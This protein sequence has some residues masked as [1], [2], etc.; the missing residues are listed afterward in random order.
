MND[1][2]KQIIPYT[3]LAACLL[4]ACQTD[5]YEPMAGTSGESGTLSLTVSANDFAVT[6]GAS[7]RAADNGKTTTFE[8]GDR[9]GL[10]VLD[11]ADGI[12]ADNLPYKFDGSNWNFD[13]NNGE[14]KQPAFYDPSMNTYIVY[15]PYNAAANQTA[16]VDALKALG[17][18]AH[19]ADQSAENA[20]RQSDLMVW[21]S[22]GTPIKQITATLAHIRNSFS[23]DVKV[24]WTLTTGDV[25]SY[26]P[27]TLE[28]V[29]LYD[30]EGTQLSPYRAEDG[31]YRYIL[32]D[33]YDGK[34]RW[35]YTYGE[36]TFGGECT[37]SAQATGTRYAQVKTVNAGE[38]S[39][40]KAAPGDFYCSKETGEAN[41]GYVVPQEAVSVLKQ[42][43]CI[44]IVFYTGRH[45]TDQSDYSKPLTENGPTIPDGKFHGYVV[46]L[47]DV[48]DGSSDRLRWEYGPGNVYNQAI[49]ASTSTSD[50]Q[51]YSNSLK[52]HEFV[53]N[54]DNK[55]A[56][57]EMKHFPAALACETYGNRTTDQDGNPA[58]GKYDWQKPLAAPSNT[59]GW[60]L[61]SCG[62]L[63]HLYANRSLLSARMT[64]VKNSTPADCNYKGKIK[65]FSTSLY[66]WSSAEYSDYPSYAWSV[67]FRSGNGYN[68]S[69]NLTGGVRAVLAF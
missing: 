68:F 18:F 49:G 50:W 69:K 43:R 25:L 36:K 20:Y 52:F 35:C 58:N 15:Y 26:T 17:V 65:W 30:K 67:Y 44:G 31:S 27:P 46:A 4:S 10:I 33:G 5:D 53:N 14:G 45:E 9:V 55:E 8:N 62:Q 59:S 34:M 47:T 57:W 48:H 13:T 40:D 11:V 66:Y 6:G 64:D 56:G 7:T 24:Q 37:V 38:Y 1:M 19:Q 16:S 21:T 23:L 2:M 29:I 41:T 54:D 3:L 32:P 51:G 63:S 28:D 42:H 12:I 61:P 60:F 22:S 39:L